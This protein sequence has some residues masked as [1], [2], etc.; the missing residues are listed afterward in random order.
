MLRGRPPRWRGHCGFPVT[1][2]RIGGISYQLRP[3]KGSPPLRAQGPA[4]SSRPREG[5]PPLADRSLLSR[6]AR[7]SL[8]TMAP[9]VQDGLASSPRLAASGPPRGSPLPTRGRLA[10]DDGRQSRPP[11]PRAVHLGRVGQALR[12]L[13]GMDRQHQAGDQH[14]PS[15]P[16]RPPQARA[17]LP[18]VQPATR[19]GRACRLSTQAPASC[20]SPTS[21]AACSPSGRRT[22]TVRQ[23]STRGATK[24][25]RGLSAM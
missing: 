8:G 2:L 6:L 10:G 11:F 15:S 24:S 14:A 1:G 22:R 13:G 21:N 5:A 9:P 4:E 18:S 3:P 19:A 23:P 7:F 17:Q 12:G 25:L 16:H 20:S